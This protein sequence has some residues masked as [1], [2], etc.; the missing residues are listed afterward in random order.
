MEIKLSE[1]NDMTNIILTG[2][3]TINNSEHA[4]EELLRSIENGEKFNIHF[5]EM[6]A[7]DLVGCQHILALQKY[8]QTTNKTLSFESDYS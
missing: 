6:T 7:I 2:E 3:F 4:K 8:C 5:S 1:K